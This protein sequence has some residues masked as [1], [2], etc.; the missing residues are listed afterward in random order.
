MKF[1]TVKQAQAW[2]ESITK[3]GEKY[4]LWRMEKACELLGNPQQKFKSVHVGGTNGKGST[5]TFLAQVLYEAG[6]QVGVYTSPYI[7]HFNERIMINQTM[8][9]DDTFLRHL[10]KIYALEQTFKEDYHDQLTFFELLTLV[11]FNVFAEAD[12]DLVIVEVGLGGLLDATNVITPILSVITTIGYD[13]MNVLG[14]SLS[15]I[16][17][18]K[19][20]IAK[21]N[22]PLVTGIKQQ[23]L[24]KQVKQHA[25]ERQIPLTILREQPAEETWFDGDQG[26]YFRGVPYGLSMLGL[27]QIDNAKT[28]LLAAEVLEKLGYL[29][30]LE[31]K[32]EGIKN[33][34]WPGRFERFGH[35][36]LEGAH[37]EPGMEAACVSLKTYFPNRKI[38]SVFTAMK[39]KDYE[40]MLNALA[41][42]SDEIIFTQIDYPRCENAETLKH[43]SSHPNARII[44][45]HSELVK[46]VKVQTDAMV[47]ITGSL[48]LI[49]AL[50]PY[51]TL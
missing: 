6:Y 41:F 5:V 43:V 49:S 24:V 28:A 33:A 13:H 30:P 9:D 4:D 26:F 37:N 25:S 17:R 3:F 50:R 39:D 45:N 47:F 51:F 22:I 31:A 19:L 40:P 8:V 38:I 2:I 35:V 23:T 34:R 14:N 10:N 42:V 36:I 7:V 11:A 1:K 27:H 21:M 18:N 46:E 29:I 16:L 44:T 12:L 20:G 15:S 48:Y 32:L